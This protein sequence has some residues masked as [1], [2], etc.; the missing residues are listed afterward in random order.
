MLKASWRVQSRLNILR[1]AVVAMRNAGCCCQPFLWIKWWWRGGVVGG[2]HETSKA[3]K[4][5]TQYDKIM[6][7]RLRGV[8]AVW[9]DTE[10]L[11][12]PASNPGSQN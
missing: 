10:S 4:Q 3:R 1:S 9:E 7:W 11:L 8:L 6:S 12:L 5:A 2:F